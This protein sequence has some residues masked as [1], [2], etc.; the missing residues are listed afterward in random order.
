ERP[1]T[2]TGTPWEPTTELELPSTQ[3]PTDDPS[4]QAPFCPPSGVHNFP[5]PGNCTL[6]IRCFDG[7]EQ[8]LSCA[9]LLF[10]KID[11]VCK[12]PSQAVCDEEIPINCP[13]EGYYPLPHPAS[14]SK[15]YEC[16]EGKAYE[17]LC[18]PS[19]YFDTTPELMHC[20]LAELALCNAE[21]PP[22]GIAFVA[23]R[24]R[25]CKWYKVCVEG[26]SVNLECGR[27]EV[28]SPEEAMCVPD[29]TYACP[30]AAN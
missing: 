25:D 20:N 16:I 6:Y 26:H 8:V 29:D 19:T 13:P 5:Y 12:P 14:C 3:P 23:I 15:Y 4:T 30:F 18:A 10:D 9:P 22:T 17:S 28:Y 7:I 27:G 1:G 2:E 11:L 21:C 24:A